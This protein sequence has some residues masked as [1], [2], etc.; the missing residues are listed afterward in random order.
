MPGLL[1]APCFATP[2][3]CALPVAVQPERTE[4]RMP[5]KPRQSPGWT[6]RGAPRGSRTS[7]RAP[8]EEKGRRARGRRELRDPRQ[9]TF[10]R[11]PQDLFSIN[12]QRDPLAGGFLSNMVFYKL[13]RQEEGVT[14]AHGSPNFKK[15]QGA[16]AQT[17]TR[18]VDPGGGERG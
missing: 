16:G 14:A 1:Q 6:P 9:R 7:A 4:P 5:L 2:H 15:C 12:C 11:E 3:P 8:R 13:R 10:P 17:P 18:S